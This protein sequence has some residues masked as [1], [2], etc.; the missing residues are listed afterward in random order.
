MALAAGVMPKTDLPLRLTALPLVGKGKTAQVSVALEITAPTGAMKDA[1]SK[2][3]DDV[4]YS[5]LVVDDKKAKVTQRTGSGAKLALTAKDGGGA[6]PDSV[7]YQ[8]PLTLDLDPGNYQLRASALSKKLDRGGSVFLD[9]T[10]PDFSKTPLA[11]T[12]I[13]LGYADGARVP[14]GRT[15]DN[16]ASR[17]GGAGSASTMMTSSSRALGGRGGGVDPTP[18]PQ[19]MT[20]A[21]TTQRP[22]FEPTL[23]REFTPA[24]ALRA[25]FEVARKDTKSTVHMTISI[26]DAAGRPIMAIDRAVLPG[27]PGRV[28]LRVPL[29]PL[30][31]LAPGAFRLRVT[32]TDSH[33]VATTETGIVV[34]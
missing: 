20:A 32:A 24:D 5:V 21:A 13:A 33:A 8:I 26:T 15:N 1:D 9:I 22:P 34:K 19:A 2:L 12:P 30:G 6:M 23:S 18:A 11:L 14:V 7:T 16:A 29:A 28:D 25:Y 10:V 17:G 3:R 4:S 31:A 27:E